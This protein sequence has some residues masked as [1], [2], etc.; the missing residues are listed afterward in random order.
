MVRMS[1][2]LY[3]AALIFALLL[4]PLCGI[5]ALFL[6]NSYALPRSMGIDDDLTNLSVGLLIFFAIAP[7]VF[8]QMILLLTVVYKMW[9]AIQDG[10]YARMTPGKAIGLLFIPFFNLYW[11]FQAWGGFPGDYNAFIDR[12]ALPVPKLSPG[13]YIVYPIVLVLSVVPVLGILALLIGPI[14]FVVL[15]VKTCDAVNRLADARERSESSQYNPRVIPQA[16][17]THAVR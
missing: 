13:L 7:F 11:V 2:R 8:T 15:M 6:L 4:L 12:H 14:V 9:A 1:K 17:A 16:R 10:P 5:P 3:L